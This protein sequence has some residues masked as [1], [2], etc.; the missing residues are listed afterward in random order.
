MVGL[1]IGVGE[2][3]VGLLGNQGYGVKASMLGLPGV[4]VFGV[5]LLA[6]CYVV[7]I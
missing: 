5:W 7:A 3:E 4:V 2:T 6:S 1:V